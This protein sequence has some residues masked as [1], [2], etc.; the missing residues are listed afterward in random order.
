[1][2]KK[3]YPRLKIFAGNSHPELA[4][5]IVQEIQGMGID[6][7]LSIV[8]VGQFSDG[9]IR[10]TDMEDVRDIDAYVLQ[11]GASLASGSKNSVNDN[12]MELF[13]MLD[14]LKRASVGKI[15]TVMPYYPYARQDKK[16]ESRA[17]ISAKALAN[18][19][20]TAGSG[21]MLL[22]DL[23]AIQIAGFFD[24]PVNHLFARPALVTDIKEHFDITD[25]DLVL[26]SPDVGGAERARA[27]AKRLNNALIAMIDKRREVANKA[28][29]MHLIGNVS[30]KR[31][32]GL[33][34]IIDTAGTVVEAAVK[35][36]DN[37]AKEMHRYA[38][39]GV[40]SGEAIERIEGCAALKSVV[41]TDTLPLSDQAKKCEKIRVVSVAPIIAQA[42]IRLHLK[43]SLS[44]L[45]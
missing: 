5:K 27:Y 21:K 45:F 36:M 20:V 6:I 43:K 34:D 13:L 15:T 2:K 19:I 14:A 37:G 1:M 22:M 32:I 24:I 3:R 44:V 8:N 41:V 30:G 38:S 35:V 39:H 4:E 11:T 12:M 9:E 31:V 10:I 33:D 26:L 16:V 28:K 42:I 17:P 40:F 18:L 23:H 25:D 29:A 7:K